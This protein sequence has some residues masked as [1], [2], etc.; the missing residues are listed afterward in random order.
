MNDKPLE[1][2]PE[3]VPGYDPDKPRRVKRVIGG[4]TGFILK[5]SGWYKSDYA[6]NSDTKTDSGKSSDLSKKT[7]DKP[8]KS[9]DTSITSSSN[10]KS[11]T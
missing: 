8:A 3:S 6:S 7:T 2:W 10:S 11:D 4:G 1:F 9:A 5:G